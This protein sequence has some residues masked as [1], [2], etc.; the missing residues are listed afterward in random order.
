MAAALVGGLGLAQAWAQASARP[1]LTVAA[2]IAAEPASQTAFA[3]RVGPPEAVPHNAFVRVRGLPPA[4]AL[5]DGHSIAPG[6]WAVSPVALPELK[7]L[8]PPGA[9]GRSEIV[10]TLV[11]VDGSVLA[12]TNATLAIAAAR[13]SERSQVRRDSSPPT[14]ASILRAGAPLQMPPEAAE[15]NGP[16]PK[17]SS[18]AITPQ[19]RERALRLMKKG[20]AQLEDGNVAAARLFYER[21]ADAGLAQG[22]MALAATF[23]ATELAR[24]KLRGVQPDPKEARRWYERARQ[25][26]ASGVEERLRRLGA[27]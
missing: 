24:L 3:I 16:A 8:L 10:V 20:D 27:S 5:S 2:T 6:V 11:A 26:G 25:L 21:A 9:A 19:D 14:T 12:E 22:A 1:V 7:I 18:Q 15:P 23:D 17:P 13:Q 4:A